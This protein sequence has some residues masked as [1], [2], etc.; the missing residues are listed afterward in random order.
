VTL[1]GVTRENA[2]AVAERL[3][4]RCAAASIRLENGGN[5]SITVSIGVA[6]GTGEYALPKLLAA[7]DTALY[8]AKEAGRDRI[9]DQTVA[10]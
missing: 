8:A 5:F 7:A 6:A 2:L 4:S 1:P 10:A 3:R 9:V